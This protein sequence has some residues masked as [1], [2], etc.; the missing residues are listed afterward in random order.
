RSG[1]GRRFSGVDVDPGG[2]ATPSPPPPRRGRRGG[3]VAYVRGPRS[4]FVG[5]PQDPEATTTTST[6][7]PTLESGVVNR[8]FRSPEGTASS[9]GA[10]ALPVHA[11]AAAGDP[12]LR[13]RLRQRAGAGPSHPGRAPAHRAAP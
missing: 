8:V 9:R 13:A 7:T 4:K 10:I 12:G 2:A 5:I 1:G 3:G 6:P 11:A